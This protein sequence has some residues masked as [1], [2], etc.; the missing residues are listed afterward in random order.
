VG[1]LKFEVGV[2]NAELEMMKKA[3]DGKKD[4]G[5]NCPFLPSTMGEF[6]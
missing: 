4:D 3:E 5:G 2:R 6:G 1:S